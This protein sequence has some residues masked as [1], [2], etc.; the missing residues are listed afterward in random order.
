MGCPADSMAEGK[1]ARDTF[2]PALCQVN[3]SGRSKGLR[4]SRQRQ[5]NSGDSPSAI[6]VAAAL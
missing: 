4:P 3:D 6:A 2:Q 5:E 1:A